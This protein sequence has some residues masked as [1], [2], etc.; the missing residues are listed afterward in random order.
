MELYESNNWKVV[1]VDW[2]QEFVGNCIISSKKESLSEL[3]DE[4]WQEL[5]K[6]S[7]SFSL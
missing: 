3:T 7:C 5:R 6:A 1:F 4:E 2:C